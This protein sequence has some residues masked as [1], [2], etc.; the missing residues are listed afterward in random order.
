MFCSFLASGSI[1]FIFCCFVSFLNKKC[2]KIW[3]LFFGNMIRMIWKYIFTLIHQWIF[4]I[5]QIFIFVKSYL[6]FLE[7]FL[8]T[9]SKVQIG[10]SSFSLICITVRR[11]RWHLV[12]LCAVHTTHNSSHLA[13]CVSSP[14]RLPSDH[15]REYVCCLEVKLRIWIFLD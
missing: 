7:I 12:H 5:L 14:G 1:N 3:E 6:S 4:E 9:N 8:K 2:Y 13:D 11:R 15:V 10:T